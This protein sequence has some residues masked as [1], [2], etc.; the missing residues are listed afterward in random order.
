MSVKVFLLTLKQNLTQTQC[1]LRCFIST[2]LKIQ[3]RLVYMI[4]TT[5][6]VAQIEEIE[7]WGFVSKSWHHLSELNL[8]SGC[9]L[10][11]SRCV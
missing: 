1:S 9:L 11:T 5:P 6:D 2:L 7:L 3:Q 4:V 10:Y 8:C